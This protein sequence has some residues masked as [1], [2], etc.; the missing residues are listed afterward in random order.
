MSAYTDS[1]I[2]APWGNGNNQLERLLYQGGPIL[3]G[4]GHVSDVDEVEVIWWPGPFAFGVIDL[5]GHV[6]GDP[7]NISVF[8]QQ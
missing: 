2:A 5:E 7:G 8:P 4:A 1:V 3:D 6:R